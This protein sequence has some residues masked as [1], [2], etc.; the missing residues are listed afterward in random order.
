M[1]KEPT[2]GSVALRLYP[3]DQPARDA[4]LAD[5]ALP[6][7]AMTFF[8]SAFPPG[9]S[10]CHLQAI[11]RHTSG[12]ENR[13]GPFRSIEGSNPSPSA[14]NPNPHRKAGSGLSCSRP[15]GSWITNRGKET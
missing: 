13:Y 14:S 10:L 5:E 12:L 4:S 6:D 8:P 3:H 1:A 11:L 9:P 15:A 7:F 2:R